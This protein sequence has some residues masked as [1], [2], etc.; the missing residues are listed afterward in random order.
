MQEN[1]RLIIAKSPAAAGEAMQTIKAIGANSPIV[2]TRYNRAVT[3]ALADPQAE[4]T[5]D[6]RAQLAEAVATEGNGLERLTL[7]VKPDQA[8]EIR[9][10]AVN[11]G[12]R[13][14]EY[15]KEAVLE[16]VEKG[17]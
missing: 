6:E 2:Q 1:L 13:L 14:S 16:R 10:A 3:M 15:L 8:K 11:A 5:A 17:G 4:F 9:H 7:Y 12:K